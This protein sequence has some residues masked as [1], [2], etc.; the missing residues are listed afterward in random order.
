MQF[1]ISSNVCFYFIMLITANKKAVVVPH[2]LTV[3]PWGNYGII[4]R[5]AMLQRVLTCTVRA[6]VISGDIMAKCKD[7]NCQVCMPVR[8][9][10]CRDILK[11]QPNRQG[12]LFLRQNQVTFGPTTS[13]TFLL[14]DKADSVA[15]NSSEEEPS[16]KRFK[17]TKE[18]LCLSAP[19]C[20]TSHLNVF[21]V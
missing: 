3:L 7:V 8:V 5:N 2:R 1:I 11:S 6:R 14:S 13:S 18:W 19:M 17:D 20:F 12:L 9:E 16:P 10:N 21:G 4:S 15:L